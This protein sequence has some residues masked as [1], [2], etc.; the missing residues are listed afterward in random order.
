MKNYITLILAMIPLGISAQDYYS[1]SQNLY[2]TELRLQLHNL[3][4][5]HTIISYSNCITA[6]KESDQA[7]N[8]SNF[9]RLVYKN[10]TIDKNNFAYDIDNPINLN[11]WNR[12][13]VWAK[14]LGDF[15]LY[16]EYED[17]PAHTDLHNLKPSDMS[18]NSDR[19]NKGFDD[20]GTQYPEALDCNYTWNS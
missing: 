2:G 1:N 18:I 4:D 14:Y 3:I 10:T 5:D 17:N 15:G 19:G 12:E 20:G 16:G 13:H 6:L 9:I 11:Y 7:S 8:N